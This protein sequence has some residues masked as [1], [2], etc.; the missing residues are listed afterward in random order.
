MPVRLTIMMLSLFVF[1]GCNI[2]E[3]PARQADKDMPEDTTRDAA[4]DIPKD[5]V[6]DAQR[7]T[8]RDIAPADMAA[9][10]TRD[11]GDDIEPDLPSNHTCQNA[12]KLVLK[13][14]FASSQLADRPA[15]LAIDGDR[16]G[17]SRWV[18]QGIPESLTIDLGAEQ[19]VYA[20]QIWCDRQNE[21]TATVKIEV[22]SDNQQF[23]EVHPQ[24]TLPAQD[25]ATPYQLN[26]V[27]ARARYVRTTWYGTSEND[28]NTVQEIEV[29]GK[30]INAVEPQFE[31]QLTYT[32]IRKTAA[33]Q[34]PMP[35]GFTLPATVGTSVTYKHPDGLPYAI[36]IHKVTDGNANGGNDLRSISEYAM[37][38]ALSAQGQYLITHGITSRQLYSGLAPYPFIRTV[39]GVDGGD[40]KDW[41]WSPTQSAVGY[42]FDLKNDRLVEYNASTDTHTVLWKSNNQPVVTTDGKTHTNLQMGHSNSAD[43]PMG[44]EGSI[45]FDG[46]V[47]AF[48]TYAGNDAVIV[49][50]DLKTK[51]V[52]AAMTLPGRAPKSGGSAL[53]YVHISPLGT[54][55]VYA[56]ENERLYA[57]PVNQMNLNNAKQ[58]D[59]NADHQDSLITNQGEQFMVAT[60]HFKHNIVTGQSSPFFDK[61]HRQYQGK[62]LGASNKSDGL[63]VISTY[64]T[65]AAA[66]ESD[67]NTALIVANVNNPGEYSWFGW[68]NETPLG[69]QGN[70]KYYRYEPHANINTQVRYA[71]GSM[72]IKVVFTGTNNDGRTGQYGDLYVAKLIA[73]P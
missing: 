1:I 45:S 20:L 19:D 27:D 44:G 35:N 25:T 6:S 31:H 56:V 58:L 30:Q 3:Q 18:S 39:Q 8:P 40:V 60:N 51:K 29:C 33:E 24:T 17:E 34:W 21:R 55:V 46:N 4:M 54:H 14:A 15:H 59:D 63:F 32:P 70:S 64:R 5:Q 66:P 61:S 52:S 53:D 2:Q 16:T 48:K 50:F 49:V 41:Q 71:D 57:V 9:D 37:H 23:T 26:L 38:Q 11:V 65:V 36:E 68:V 7:D 47:I 42:Y 28:Y 22:S 69:R 10:I 72:G 43:G 67:F 62:H 13:R 12:D 73:N